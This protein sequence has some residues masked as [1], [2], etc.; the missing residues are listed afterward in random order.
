MTSL[1]V[2]HSRRDR[3]AAEGVSEWL[4][5][6]GLIP[7][8]IDFDPDDVP[9]G[10]SWERELYVKLRRADAV[11]FLASSSSV[12][13][14]WCFAEITLARSLDRPIFPLRLQVNL[15]LPLFDDVQW[16]DPVGGG[17]T[18]S[19]AGGIAGGWVGFH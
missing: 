11:I 2:S 9:E 15:G 5:A 10:R 12:D 6:T 16:T 18:W 14:R 4:R 19:F 17:Q 13:S 3:A 8:F 1:F 7:L